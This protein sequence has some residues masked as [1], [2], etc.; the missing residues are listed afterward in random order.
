MFAGNCQSF[1]AH[2]APDTPPPGAAVPGPSPSSPVSS[3][4]S[5][6]EDADPCALP[7]GTDFPPLS[8]AGGARFFTV[9]ATADGKEA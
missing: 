3:P 6:A 9:P 7:A 4:L 2:L 1:A 8:P 5:V